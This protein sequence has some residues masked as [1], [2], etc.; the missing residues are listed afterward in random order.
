MTNLDNWQ[1]NFEALKV[2]VTQTGYYPNQHTRLNKWCRYQRKRNKAGV[3]P[4]EQRYLFEQLAASR[5]SEHTGGRKKIVEYKVTT[6]ILYNS[7]IL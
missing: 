2:H 3:M 6:N 5:S 7:Q 4:E 1:V